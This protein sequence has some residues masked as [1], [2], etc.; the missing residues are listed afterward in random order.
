MGKKKGSSARSGMDKKTMVKDSSTVAVRKNDIIK[1]T[2]LRQERRNQNLKNVYAKVK[3]LRKIENT[4]GLE[5]RGQIEEYERILDSYRVKDL[6]TTEY[7]A[8]H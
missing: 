3:N 1:S 4:G 2:K 6:R 7:L 8:T 5:V